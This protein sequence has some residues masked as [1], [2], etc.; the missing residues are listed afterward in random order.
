MTEQPFV[1][2]LRARPGVLRLG[3]GGETM[4]VRVEIPEQWDVVVVEASPE[5]TVAEIKR[6]A[7]EA[8]LGAGALPDDVVIKLNGFEVLNEQVSLTEAGAKDGSTFLAMY[9]RRRPVR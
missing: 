2:A 7:V 8:I 5:I 1:A 3:K 6:A 4:T 9:R